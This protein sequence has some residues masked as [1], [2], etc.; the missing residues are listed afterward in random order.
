M[1]G[2][3]PQVYGDGEEAEVTADSITEAPEEVAERD[4][5]RSGTTTISLTDVVRRITRRRWDDVN[6][7]AEELASAL[8]SVRVKINGPLSL[9]LS[10]GQAAIQLNSEPD[11]EGSDVPLIEE[12]SG[13]GSGRG[14][15]VG[16]GANGALQPSSLGESFTGGS[17]VG[18]EGGGG[19]GI[20][21][22]IV[23]GSGD[24]YQVSLYEDGVAGGVTQ[25]VEA[26][27]LQI[28]EAETIPAGTWTFASLVNEI[29]YIQVPVW[30]EEE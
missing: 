4:R 30:A 13:G 27:Q 10:K 19:G 17:G 21:C 12:V 3:P 14:S 8:R 29:Y 15:S 20:P 9:N 24:T 28:D 2:E 16:I 23:S 5:S 7:L 1:S 18:G 11:P 6:D 26:I 25:T 22:A